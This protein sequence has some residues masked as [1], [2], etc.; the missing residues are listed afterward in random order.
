MPA[1]SLHGHVAVYVT[2]SA[3]LVI[4][5]SALA[6]LD[7]ERAAPDANITTFPDALW[8]AVTTVTTVGYGDHFPTTG[9]G[10]LIAVGLMIGGIALLGVVTATLASWFVQHVT[11]SEQLTRAEVE[12][13]TDEVRQLR[14]RLDDAVR[15]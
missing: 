4:F 13:L 6:I 15:R 12:R 14:A 7:A 10:R 1:R 2:G 11:E 3:A 8:W 9:L 5:C